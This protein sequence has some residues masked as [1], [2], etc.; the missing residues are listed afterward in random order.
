MD[1]CTPG[2]P[3]A[4]DATCDL[5]DDDCDGV[6]DEDF[7]G[8][9]IPCGIGACAHTVHS[10]CSN[11]GISVSCIS[12]EGRADNDAN[13]NR[14]DDDCD[15]QVDE[16]APSLDTVCNGIDDDCDGQVDEDFVP[17]QITC[18]QGVCQQTTQ[19]QCAFGGEVGGCEPGPALSAFDTT[20]DL[21]DDNCNGQV[22]EGVVRVPGL[23][24]SDCSDGIDNDCDGV[25][26]TADVLD[27]V[28]ND[29]DA[30][31][32]DQILEGG[33]CVNFPLLLPIS[34]DSCITY[35][36]N[37]TVGITFEETNCD[38]GNPCTTD[39]CDSGFSL[40]L[41]GPCRHENTCAPGQCL[42]NCDDGNPCTK[43]VCDPVNATA[44]DGCIHPPKC[45]DG[46]ACTIDACIAGICTHSTV[47]LC[48]PCDPIHCPDDGDP[49]TLDCQRGPDDTSFADDRCAY[50]N[51]ADTRFCQDNI[52]IF[53][54]A[55]CRLPICVAVNNEPVCYTVTVPGC[56]GNFTVPFTDDGASCQAQS[57]FCR[58]CD[59]I[60]ATD[61]SNFTLGYCR[62]HP[63]EVC[64]KDADCNLI[65]SGDACV[66]H[67]CACDPLGSAGALCNQT[68][69]LFF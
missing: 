25:I 4:N 21:R 26:D 13:C 64:L 14:I 43:D 62:D 28:C 55:F 27:C 31:T 36:C 2:T 63:L 10:Q 34:F 66:T 50:V 16:D 48:D 57:D 39:T 49:C 12:L 9:D 47:N 67:F 37:K 59:I 56:H 58:T 19:T 15:G 41:G 3:A 44:S 46:N 20:C 45:D 35:S 65:R 24:E 11:G 38:D 60:D 42:N 7:Q 8:E 33:T 5:W 51:L 52:N 69:G 6:A 61:P 22:D 53:D 32:D 1:T 30:C 40:L 23:R 18:G 29:H 54:Y 17:Q 68:P